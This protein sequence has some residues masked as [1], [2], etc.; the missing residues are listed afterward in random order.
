MPIDYNSLLLAIGIAGACLSTTLFATWLSSRSERF[1]LTWSIGAS[2]IVA[3]VFVY[4]RYVVDPAQPHLAIVAFSLLVLGLAVVHGAAVQFRGGGFRPAQIGW[5]AGPWLAVVLAGFAVGLDG[6]GFIFANLAAAALLA[7]TAHQYWLARAEAP[8]PML[9][10]VVFHLAAATS[11]ALCA[12]VLISEGALVLD[13]APQNWAEDVNVI[14]GIVAFAGIGSLSL[15]LNQSRLARRHRREAET[16]AL[17]GLVNRRALFE[18]YRARSLPE[19]A[20]VMVFD[21][22]DF[23]GVNDR[24]GHSFGDEALRRFAGAMLRSVRGSDVCARLGGEEFALVLLPAPRR[25]AIDIAERIRVAFGMEDL[26][27]A[28]GPVRCTV[29]AGVAICGKGGQAFEDVL[30]AADQALYQAKRGGRNRVVVEGLKLVA[31]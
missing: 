5:T 19:G 28:H 12:A 11:F 9:G 13:G 6:L 27:S 8:G 26:A 23:K 17:T 29:S 16:D 18:R 1:L 2:L 24:Y 7:A 30:A 22:D 10:V 3:N 20:A 25:S 21:L 31:G 4:S 14:T 15:A